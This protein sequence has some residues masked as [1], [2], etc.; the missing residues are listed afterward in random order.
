[1]GYSIEVGDAAGEDQYLIW[2]STFQMS[3]KMKIQT[4]FLIAC[5][6]GVVFSQA[7][8]IN[9]IKAE[10]TGSVTIDADFPGGNI[11]I[12]SN[13]K[14][15][16]HLQPDLRGDNPWFYWYFRAKVEKPGRVRFVFP[17][18]VAGFINGGIGNQGPGISVDEGESWQWMGTENVE[19]NAFFYDF[20]DGAKSEVR[21]AVTIPY[22]QGNLQRFIN[23]NKANPQLHISELTTSRKGR[24]VD[25]LQIGTSEKPKQKVLVTARHH[26]AETMASYVLEGFMQEAMAD[27][28]AGKQF[29]E[30]YTLFAVPIVDTDGVEEGDQGKNRKPHDHNRDY[31]DESIYPEVQSIMKLGEIHRFEFAIDF[32]CP[33]LIMPDHQVMYFVGAKRHPQFNYENVAEFCKQIKNGLPDSAPHGPLN[34]LRDEDDRSPKNSRFFGFQKQAIMS[35]TLEFPFAPPKR[36]TDIASCR[37]YGKTI[38]RAFVETR[39]QP[40]EG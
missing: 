14:G 27:T 7:L 15:V 40:P 35:A 18:K 8:G 20:P 30:R 24:T 16:V 36:K 6:F 31:K 28:E 39:F 4:A 19:A 29:R 37:E 25:L 9:I 1:M 11:K 22:T 34:W 38:L 2:P 13:E 12:N 32:H 21:F 26:A 33:T 5:L 17:E 23:K 3:I 10:D